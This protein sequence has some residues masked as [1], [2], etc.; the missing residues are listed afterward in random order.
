MYLQNVLQ[1]SMLTGADST[2]KAQIDI[3]LI[4]QCTC[5]CRAWLFFLGGGGDLREMTYDYSQRTKRW[6]VA[7]IGGKIYT[8]WAVSVSERTAL[9][10]I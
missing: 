3:P 10:S 5:T 1:H 9:T 2:S 8:I 7:I 6:T 4:R